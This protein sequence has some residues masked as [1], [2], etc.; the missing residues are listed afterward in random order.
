VRPDSLFRDRVT[1]DGA[2]GFK[3]EPG[4][5]RLITAP[6]RPSAHRTVLDAS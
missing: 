4:R 2:L 5:Y 6:S 3:A 1:R